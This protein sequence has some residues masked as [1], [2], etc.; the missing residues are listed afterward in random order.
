MS[1]AGLVSHN[2]FSVRGGEPLRGGSSR[3]VVAG[4]GNCFHNSG[5]TS[6]TFFATNS[7]LLILRAAAL[8]RA[9]LI[10]RRS[11]STPTNDSIASASSIPKKPTPQ[12]KSTKCRAPP[13][14]TNLRTVSTSFGNRK[15]LFWKNE[16]GGTS[17]SFGSVR[18][19]TFNPPRGGGCARTYRS[20][21]F[22]AGSAI[23][24][25]STSSTRPQ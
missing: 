5:K 22:R 21:S 15:K 19:T 25:S 4:G 23:L 1:C 13:A 8:R 2:I 12:Y 7:P 17:Q 18:N 9:D 24:H 3:T 6:S 11:Y 20:C 16:S 10:A 14:E